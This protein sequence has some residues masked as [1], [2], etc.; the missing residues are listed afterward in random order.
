MALGC[1][2]LKQV[3]PGIKLQSQQF[4]PLV[5]TIS[6]GGLHLSV[7]SVKDWPLQ[8][9]AVLQWLADKSF[10]IE[11]WVPKQYHRHWVVLNDQDQITREY[12]ERNQSKRRQLYDH[13]AVE[14]EPD[15]Q[16]ATSTITF[17]NEHPVWP[18]A[19][20]VGVVL[21]L[22]LYVMVLCWRRAY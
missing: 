19:L 7:N 10:P 13:F 3:S 6:N 1:A 4:M 2:S 16:F 11:R 5:K 12:Y 20:A 8:F 22:L 17:W 15:K 9:K 14:V 21:Y 18:N